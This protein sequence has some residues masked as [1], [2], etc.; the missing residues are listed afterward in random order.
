MKK[1][2]LITLS[3]L[4]LFSISACSKTQQ[5]IQVETGIVQTPVSTTQPKETATPQPT[6]EPESTPVPTVTPQPTTTPK[7]DYI[8]M[9]IST[10]SDF[11]NIRQ[12]PNTDSD[13]LGQFPGGKQ[14]G[15]IDTDGNWV[16]IYY[17]DIEGYVHSDYT[18]ASSSPTVEV[19]SG[20]WA[21]I[22]INPTHLLPDD[23]DIELEDFEGGQINAR[24]FE[25][26]TAMFEDAA[27]DG[28]EFK[29]VDS[30]RSYDTQAGY[31]EKKVQQYIDQGYSR[32]D[33]EVK[34]ATIT[35]R[36]N[37]SEHQA[38]LALDIVTPSWP[39]RNSGFAD[40]LAF[41][42]LD[43]NA[44]KYGFIHR[45]PK[46]KEDITKVI[47]EPWHWRFVG[48]EIASAI[49]ESG[50]CLEEYLGMLE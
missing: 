41:K 29:L 21:Q 2:L 11:V 44:Y 7:F 8:G 23:Y 31:Y 50:Q 40:T 16:H 39:R 30:Y 19:P 13:I 45:Y 24:I 10:A 9:V 36:P 22:L 43:A 28:V 49:E 42:W 27:E 3:I 5:T 4:F 26:A 38:G 33:A 25:I 35:A 1:T 14:A 32:E 20:D 18:V 17:E 48:T 47:F 37:T 6:D 15:V 12:Q 46:G 34:A